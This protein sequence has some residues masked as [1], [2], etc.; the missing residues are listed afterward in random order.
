MTAYTATTTN[1]ADKVT[2]TA[3]D[4]DAEVEIMLGSTEITNGENATWESGENELTIT[5]SEYGAETA[6]TV[7]VTKTPEGA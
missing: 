4:S 2:A 3:S 7:T 1:D 6:Y 5:V